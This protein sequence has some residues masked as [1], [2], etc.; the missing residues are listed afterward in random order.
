[1]GAR[2]QYHPPGQHS[3][4]GSRP[5]AYRR[6]RGPM[7]II[8]SG[9]VIA[10]VLGLALGLHFGLRTRGR[11]GESPVPRAAAPTSIWQPPVGATWQIVLSR[12]LRVEANM[13]PS[14]DVF[15]I[16]M[17]LHAKND[18]IAHLHQLGKKVICYFSAGSYE[19]YRQ[20]S[21]QF[22]PADKG[23]VMDGW[24]DENWVDIRSANVR[25]IMQE[26]IQLASRIGCDAVD[27][28]NVDGYVGWPKERRALLPQLTWEWHTS[29][30]RT[31]SI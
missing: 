17:Q 19:P 24:A 9:I 1:M 20:D 27:P 14:V 13:T 30:T 8:V 18:V 11:E 28:D 16:D 25:R 4:D 2:Y 7:I 12:T 22:L 3:A 10:I 5:R 29:K 15:D 6:G 26:R 31:A 21:A 23:A